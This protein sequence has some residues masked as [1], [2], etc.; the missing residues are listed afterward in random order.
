MTQLRLSSYEGLQGTIRNLKTPAIAVVSNPRLEGRKVIHI[1]VAEF[2]CIC[3]KTGLPDFA[4]LYIDHSPGLFCIEESLLQ[5]Y[6]IFYRNVGIFHEHVVNKILDD[7]VKA[8][9]PRWVTIRGEFYPRGGIKTTVYVQFGKE[10]NT[11]ERGAQ[12]LAEIAKP[13]MSNFKMPKLQV[14]KNQYSDRTYKVRMENQEVTFLS[15]ETGLPEF[16]T[17]R[18]EYL[19]R[20]L[21]VELKSLKIYTIAYRNIKIS[22]DQLVSQVFYDFVMAVKPLCARVI[23]SRDGSQ[24]LTVL[25]NRPS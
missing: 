24:P 3:P 2:T 1:K 7:L 12:L 14:W 21:C 10:P 22:S 20:F 18:I 19:P 6:I 8:L 17:I 13:K 4:T 23:N 25:Q 15:P 9:K 11:M 5:K 16:A